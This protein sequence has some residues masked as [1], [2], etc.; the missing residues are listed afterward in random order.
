MTVSELFKVITLTNISEYQVNGISLPLSTLRT[1]Y[2]DEHIKTVTIKAKTEVLSK[3]NVD[4]FL[5]D[6]DSVVP[7]M[8][9]VLPP[10]S[11]YT[12]ILL[13]ITLER[14]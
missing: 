3:K 14:S 1:L 12:H 11:N 9:I 5:L 2:S 6:C 4:I 13:D 7:E 10:F 8:E